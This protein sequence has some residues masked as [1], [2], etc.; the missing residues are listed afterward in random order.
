MSYNW[1]DLEKIKWKTTGI[2]RKHVNK[3]VVAEANK[4]MEKPQRELTENLPR[5]TANRRQTGTRQS[6]K[7]KKIILFREAYLQSKINKL[8]ILNHMV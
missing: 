2:D 1:K 3:K 6:Q 7:H 4:I 5:T 8:I